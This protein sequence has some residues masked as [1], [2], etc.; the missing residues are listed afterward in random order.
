MTRPGRL[1]CDGSRDLVLSFAAACRARCRISAWVR[2]RPGVV[3]DVLVEQRGRNLAGSS[4]QDATR[5]MGRAARTWA[6]GKWPKGVRR[7]KL[8]AF[9]LGS[10]QERALRKA[11]TVAVQDAAVEMSPSV[12]QARQFAMVI[13]EV[14][15]QPVPDV[16]LAR[17]ATLLEGLAAGI[18]RQLASEL[19]GYPKCST[20]LQ[21]LAAKRQVLA[22][23]GVQ[24][25]RVYL[26]EGRAAGPICSP[27]NPTGQAASTGPA[28]RR[29]PPDSG[30]HDPLRRL[31]P[32]AGH[33]MVHRPAR[34]CL[35][36]RYRDVTMRVAPKWCPQRSIRVRGV[37]VRPPATRP[38]W[39]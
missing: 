19:I 20:V 37:G 9:A 36:D 17:P 18:A 6:G 35:R 38:D 34:Y 10:D 21:D 29:V 11:A 28:G 3:A 13:S 31:D 5:R 8:T 4:G 23:F 32:A 14:F 7:K 27:W 26:E 16:P 12:E 22:A 2:A 24:D 1:G 33:Y 30:R 15:R 25:D 39:L